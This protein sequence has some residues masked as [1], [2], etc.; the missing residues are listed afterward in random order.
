MHKKFSRR[1]IPVIII[2][3]AL[4]VFIFYRYKSNAEIGRQA[5]SPAPNH[6]VEGYA[7]IDDGDSIKIGGQRIRL[8]GIDAVELHQFCSKNRT[9][10]PCGRI[11]ADYLRHL[12]DDKPVRCEWAERDKYSR[13]LGHCFAGNTD[14]NRMMVKS[15]WAINYTYASEG[16][17]YRTEEREARAARRGI[18]QGKFQIPKYWRKEHPRHD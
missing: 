9:E 10:Y 3:I 8:V 13:I 4:A 2:L 14:L 7:K 16:R 1:D 6:M 18:W 17:G 12:I 11:A 5:L 15:G